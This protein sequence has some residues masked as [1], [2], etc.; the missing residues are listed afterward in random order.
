MGTGVLVDWNDE[1]G[2][3]FIEEDGR[4]TFVHVSAFDLRDGRPHAGA[5]VRYSLGAAPDGRARAIQASIVPAAGSRPRPVG[6]SRPGRGHPSP[7][8]LV[9]AGLFLIGLT[10]AV[11]RLDLPLLLPLAYLVMSL[12][13]FGLYAVDKAAATAGEWRTP[14]TRLHLAALLC[15]WPGAAL[16]QQLLRHKNRKAQFQA[17]FWVSVVINVVMC[18]LFAAW[19]HGDLPLPRIG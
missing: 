8:P 5:G 2:F 14:E 15:G 18:V 17:V 12:A 19:L 1:R 13:T 16:A 11:L 9:V 10:I 4:R 7:A 3:G 6:R